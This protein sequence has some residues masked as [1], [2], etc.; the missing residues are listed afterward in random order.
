MRSTLACAMTA[1]GGLLAG[2]LLPADPVTLGPAPGWYR[3]MRM[4]LKDAPV[5]ELSAQPAY[6]STP[7]YG[8]LWLGDGEDAVHTVVVDL[9]EGWDEFN[10]AYRSAEGKLEPSACPAR[11]D[12]R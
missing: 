11:R 4:E 7:L 6:R 1:A 5:E 8:A 9:G 2:T 10:A 12:C 3:P